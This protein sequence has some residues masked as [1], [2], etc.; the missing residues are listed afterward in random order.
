[1]Q[2]GLAL[3]PEIALETGQEKKS[4]LGLQGE[5]GRWLRLPSVTPMPLDV[6]WEATEVKPQMRMNALAYLRGPPGLVSDDHIKQDFLPPIHLQ[7]AV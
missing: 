4:E 2:E 3:G 5:G 1:M 6:I 7:R